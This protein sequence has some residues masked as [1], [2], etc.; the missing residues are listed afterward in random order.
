MA[1]FA[2][3]DDVAR[4]EMTITTLSNK[5]LANK[6]LISDEYLAELP[7]ETITYGIKQPADV[8]LSSIH[9]DGQ[10]AEFDVLHK[11]TKFLHAEHERI[12]EPQLYS[13]AA[14][15][16]M[17]IEFDMTP[18]SIEEGISSLK[19]VSGRMQ[20]LK[21]INDSTIIDD[22]YNASP[23]AMKAALDTLYRLRA[24]QKIAILGNMNELGVYSQIEHQKVGEYCDH[25]ELDLVVT[26]GPDANKYLAGAAE[27]KGCRVK[28]FQDPYSV[29]EY[30]K[31]II[32]D[33]A[34]ILAKGSQNSVFAEETV[35]LLLANPADA[36]KLVR[37]SKDWLKKKRKAFSV[38]M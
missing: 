7:G 32:K 35:K 31:P 2:D 1:F 6:D 13:I 21:G 30:L 18:R 20:H 4:E 9:F 10:E 14:A 12:T 33:G 3:L 38:K 17:G 26:I 36:K 28:T 15:A 23:E 25:R 22:T 34:V 11:D 37:Q 19:P 16:A 29:A 8:R 27:A 24:P 5:L